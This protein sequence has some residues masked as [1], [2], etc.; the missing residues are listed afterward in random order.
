M[1][2]NLHLNE[3]NNSY[4]NRGERVNNTLSRQQQNKNFD[5]GNYTTTPTQGKSEK[6]KLIPAEEFQQAKEAFKEEGKPFGKS[7]PLES[8]SR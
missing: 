6:V 1:P 3:N 5:F 7:A 8:L 4:Q 2:F